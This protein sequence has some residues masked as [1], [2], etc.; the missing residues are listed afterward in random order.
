MFTLDQVMARTVSHPQNIV[1]PVCILF[2]FVFSSL[3][4]A[5]APN[6]RYTSFRPVASK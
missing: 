5:I 2:I 3:T 1:T 6:I 4:E